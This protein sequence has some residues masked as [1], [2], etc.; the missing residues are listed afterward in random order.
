MVPA[1]KDKVS[2]A[3]KSDNNAFSDLIQERKS[4]IYKIAY[5]YMKNR[6]DALDIVNDVVYKAFISMK[7]LKN[8]EFY[9]GKQ[10]QGK[11]EVKLINSHGVEMD[12]GSLSWHVEKIKISTFIQAVRSSRPAMKPMANGLLSLS[13]RKVI[14]SGWILV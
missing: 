11:H 8:P 6:E 7:K 2:K 5:T 14:V 13:H 3:C 1:D 9:Q 4:D 10:L 12:G